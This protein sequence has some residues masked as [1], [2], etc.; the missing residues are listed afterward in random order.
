MIGFAAAAAVAVA[1]AV[2]AAA[3]AVRQ[4]QQVEAAS[5]SSSKRRHG[6]NNVSGTRRTL[7]GCLSGP[8]LNN[9]ASYD[10]TGFCKYDEYVK[11]KKHSRSIEA[12]SLSFPNRAGPLTNPSRSNQALLIY[13]PIHKE[14]Y[15]SAGLSTLHP[16]SLIPVPRLTDRSTALSLS[17]SPG[18]LPERAKRTRKN[19]EKILGWDK[20]RNDGPSARRCRTPCGECQQRRKQRAS[21]HIQRPRAPGEPDPFALCQI[22]DLGLGHGYGRRMLNS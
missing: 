1:V 5:K 9:L 6:G 20:K 17:P 15:I 16:V 10:V 4:K 3:A 22:L 12:T 8:H 18:A 14:V 13:Y 7:G 11:R 21:R 19:P 2:A